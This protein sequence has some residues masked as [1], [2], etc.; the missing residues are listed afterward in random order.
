MR[1]TTAPIGLS[2]CALLMAAAL[3]FVATDASAHGG[4][5]RLPVIDNRDGLPPLPIPPPPPPPPETPPPAPLPP[6]PPVPPPPPPPP[7]PHPPELDPTTPR[8]SDPN[9]PP[10]PR[11]NPTTP[12]AENPGDPEAPEDNNPPPPPAPPTTG[13]PEGGEPADPQQPPAGPPQ[14]DPTPKGKKPVVVGRKG[15]RRGATAVEAWHRWWML[16]RHAY[17]PARQD[18]RAG[19]T[20]GDTKDPNALA[21][22]RRER[23]ARQWILPMLVELLDP[24]KHVD[25]EVRASAVIALTKLANDAGA[26]GLAFSWAT[27]R[28]ASGMVQES[29]ALALGLVR[30][31]KTTRQAPALELDRVRAGLLDIFDDP[32]TAWRPRVF[33]LL[34]LGMLGDQP[35]G[36]GVHRNGLLLSRGL[37]MRLTEKN[38]NTEEVVG[39]LTALGMQPRDGIP[40]TVQDSLRRIAIGKRMFGRRWSDPERA[41]A[42]TAIAR[43][44]APGWSTWLMR[45]LSSRHSP[46]AVRRAAWIAVGAR[47]ADFT[48][49]ERDSLARFWKHAKKH[50]REPI[51]RGLMNLAQ[52]RLVAADLAAKRL[53]LLEDTPLGRTLLSNAMGGQPEVRAFGMLGL[54]LAARHA[55]GSDKGDALIQDARRVLGKAFAKGNPSLR[56]AAAVALGLLGLDEETRHE[57][58]SV[59]A[60][61]ASERTRACCAVALAQQGQDDPEL[62]KTLVHALWDRRTP[63][64]RAEAGL[65]LSFLPRR[66]EATLLVQEFGKPGTSQWVLGQVAGALGRL[67]DVRVVPALIEAAK[68]VRNGDQA[69]GIAIASLGLIADT[70]PT[71]SLFRLAHEG[72]FPATTWGWPR[73]GRSSDARGSD[74]DQHPQHIGTGVQHEQVQAA[75]VVQIADRCRECASRDRRGG[76]ERPVAR[77]VEAKQAGELVGYRQVRDPVAVQ[78]GDRGD[79][80]EGARGRL[81]RRAD[82]AGTVPRKEHEVVLAPGEHVRVSVGVEVPDVNPRHVVRC[83]DDCRRTKRPVGGAGQQTDRVVRCLTE[84]GIPRPVAVQIADGQRGGIGDRH[85]RGCAKGPV[86]LAEHRH[87]AVEVVQAHQVQMPVAVHV[88]RMRIEARAPRQGRRGTELASAVAEQQ[89]EAGRDDVQVPVFVEVR[90]DRGAA[91]YGERHARQ[92]PERA[93]AVAEQDGQVVAVLIG[94]DHV[95]VAIAVEVAQRKARRRVAHRVRDRGRERATA[96]IALDRRVR[97]VVVGTTQHV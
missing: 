6:A 44:Q 75:V 3:V 77:A 76:R 47:A 52:G 33:A 11:S 34:A 18:G 46:L 31:T 35:F 39:L 8:P 42:V 92:D 87:E 51:T 84:D 37:W 36:E 50:S 95:Q 32:Y 90:N 9:N 68:N 61:K 78:V 25:E 41:H 88:P 73:P 7:P 24:K 96:G 74:P 30:R 85:L 22:E 69:R 56:S 62:R 94:H 81:Q 13:D 80:G 86:A 19:V 5:V 59:L 57:M 64:L 65:A 67:A 21:N 27:D 45:V 23:A 89:E 29:A 54:A 15:P 60:S 70:E 66:H 16:N 53:N 63:E 91:A 2:V 49:D 97:V 43:M 79:A 93:I 17:L 38:R 58:G 10:P 20:T 14:T 28:N 1:R 48:P 83:R 26:I 55:Q 82:T 71:P 12:P 4:N 72:N 40:S